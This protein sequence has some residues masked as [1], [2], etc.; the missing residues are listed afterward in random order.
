MAQVFGGLGWFFQKS[1]RNVAWAKN[2][3]R[4]ILCDLGCSIYNYFFHWRMLNKHWHAHKT[5]L[6][7]QTTK[8][9]LS[10]AE[11]WKSLKY[12]QFWGL[13]TNSRWLQ[14]KSVTF[15]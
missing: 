8:Q 10:K 6:F 5:C 9:S 11:S 1:M 14:T 15:N 13:E 7:G 4:P 2:L 3:G 12:Q